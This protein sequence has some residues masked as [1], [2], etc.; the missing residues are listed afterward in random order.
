MRRVWDQISNFGIT[1]KMPLVEQKSLIL[2]NRL[3]IMLAA[4]V[5]VTSILMFFSMGM[6][7][8]PISFLITLP[9]LALNLNLNRNGYAK[10]SIFVFTIFFSLF[11]T[12]SSILSKIYGEGTTIIYVIAPKF[13]I[14]ITGLFAVLFFGALHKRNLLKALLP[15]AL[16]F[17]G[18]D[19][20]HRF[21]G[22]INK[23]TAY[24]RADYIY[25]TIGLTMIFLLGTVIFLFLQSVNAA[26]ESK[27]LQQTQAIEASRILA[28]K[29]RDEITNAKQHLTDSIRY[30]RKIQTAVLPSE[31][32]FEENF[33]DFF[34]LNLPRDIVSGDFYFSVKLRNKIFVS[35]ADCTGH[36]VPG[37]LMS[38]LGVTF[39]HQII[40]KTESK[41]PF[42][43]DFA[44][45]LTKNIPLPFQ[46]NDE[47][48]AGEILNS[49]RENIKKSLNQ[50]DPALERREGMDMVLCIIDIETKMMQFAG[51][52]N[53]A[54]LISGSE[55]RILKGDRMPI[56][57]SIKEVPFQTQTVQLQ[58]ADKLYLFSDG[59]QDQF[60]GD[61]NR[62]YKSANFVNLLQATSSDSMREQ[63]SKIEQE[64]T[65]WRKSYEQTDDILVVG[66]KI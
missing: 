2:F 6:T 63:G 54:V 62:K 25:I 61:K 47:P 4:M 24:E 66:L 40:G 51:A 33:S 3:I 31:A 1:S 27:I 50:N 57:I 16:F 35:V 10:H 41:F 15:S 23:S 43:P 42:I 21:F 11:F 49:L 32:I 19:T 60:G 18:F 36:G 53:S 56:G 45:R 29:Q 55:L 17:L 58:V 13:G 37:A 8:I 5:V 28:L 26:Y 30:A 44:K 34:I 7:I 22:I 65:F 20:I 46:K 59:F 38:M 12:L 9:V 52:H 48:D 64:H 39:L 14:L